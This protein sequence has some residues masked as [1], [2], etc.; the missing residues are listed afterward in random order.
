M[1]TYGG[2]GFRREEFIGSIA[3]RVVQEAQ[4][5]VITIRPE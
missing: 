2:G 3:E 1:M 5:P 4:C